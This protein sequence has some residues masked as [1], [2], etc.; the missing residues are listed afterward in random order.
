MVHS[1]A[2]NTIYQKKSFVSANFATNVSDA[3]FA[4]LNTT[5]N[6]ILTLDAIKKM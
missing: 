1:N 2:R 6:S 4:Y 3:S 5:I